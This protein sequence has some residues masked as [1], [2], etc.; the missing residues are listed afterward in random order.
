MNTLTWVGTEGYIDNGTTK[1]NLAI[2][3]ALSFAYDALYYEPADGNAF[4]VV[5][6]VKTPLTTNDINS[7]SGYLAG[8]TG[9][10]LLVQGVDATGL[11][12]GF[13]QKSAVTAIV[14]APPPNSEFWRWDFTLGQYV[15]IQGVDSAGNY[16]GNVAIGTYFKDVGIAPPR[17]DIGMQ[18]SFTTNSWVDVRAAAVIAAENLANSEAP[19]LTAV[20]RHLDVAAK[21]KGY[22]NIVSACSYAGAANPFQTEGQAYVTWRGDCWDYCNK[23][24]AAVNAGTRSAPTPDGLVSELPP[25]P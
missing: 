25:S 20:Q 15:H 5:S 11:Y 21:S 24:L 18:W 16:L 1:G 4:C 9:G 6:G 10:D 8:F 2:K 13:K 17:L 14:I 3:P 19:Y 7:V 22:D 23:Q 12:V